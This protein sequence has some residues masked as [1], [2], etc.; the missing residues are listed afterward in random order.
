MTLK[1]HT[2]LLAITLCAAFIIIMSSCSSD[3]SF[4]SNDPVAIVR[5]DELPAHKLFSTNDKNV[6]RIAPDSPLGVSGKTSGKIFT[7]NDKSIHTI[8]FYEPDV[9][10][11]L[12][13]LA[14]H[15]EGTVGA[16]NI[17][18]EPIQTKAISCVVNGGSKPGYSSLITITSHTPDI[19]TTVKLTAEIPGIGAT[20]IKIK[21]KGRY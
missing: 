15:L 9:T 19:D 14:K 21:V 16:A 3:K 18:I 8:E 20:Y 2:K 13:V 7:N 5:I 1:L 11:T 17:Y 10:I 4:N 12:G 6:F